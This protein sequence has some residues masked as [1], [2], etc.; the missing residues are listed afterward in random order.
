MCKLCDKFKPKAWNFCPICGKEINI[1]RYN[2]DD[3]F[4]DLLKRVGVKSKVNW[5]ARLTE[6]ELEELWNKETNNG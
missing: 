4:E 2:T 5:M 3:T 6:E 1:P